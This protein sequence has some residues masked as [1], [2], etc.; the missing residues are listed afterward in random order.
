M[1]PL[2][3]VFIALNIFL[4]ITIS[5]CTNS[6]ELRRRELA[7]ER[8]SF[9]V[10]YEAQFT[11]ADFAEENFEENLP[12]AKLFTKQD[13]QRDTV[14][15]TQGFRVQIYISDN[16]D[17]AMKVKDDINVKLE[18]D[19]VYLEFDSPLYKVRVGDY[20]TRT[21][22]MEIMNT[23]IAMGYAKAWIVPTAIQKSP[24]PKPFIPS[25]SLEYKEE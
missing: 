4:F 19:W 18:Y 8:K 25:D 15:T 10:K 12:K 24:P 14:L 11:P 22:A 2:K 5:S 9:L 6:D 7:E 3:S 16:I 17:S 23:L 21:D 1:N 20:A 13:F